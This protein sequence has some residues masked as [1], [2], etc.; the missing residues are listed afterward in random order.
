MLILCLRGAEVGT[1]GRL[2]EERSC[3]AAPLVDAVRPFV[4]RACFGQC[5]SSEALQSSAAEILFR[6]A[7]T[8]GNVVSAMEQPFDLAEAKAELRAPSPATSTPVRRVP[9]DA[10]VTSA[11][12]VAFG[13]FGVCL[14]ISV[15]LGWE[16]FL[17]LVFLTGALGAAV[18]N[19]RHLETIRRAERSDQA[20]LPSTFQVYASL[21]VGGV[22]GF[23]MYALCAAGFLE[24]ALF[25]H[26]VGRD[27]PFS[28]VKAFV[29]GQAPAT[30]LDAGRALV[31]AF[32]AGWSEGTVSKMLGRLAGGRQK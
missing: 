5:R 2:D 25:P 11:A 28:T 13:L 29:E 31:W 10:A 1:I 19:F 14:A 9:A 22:L 8:K 30:N 4:C 16:L 6:D 24:G 12:A 7:R 20:L 27:A 21:L 15:Q 26:F 3:G 17:P 23:V 18:N 32:I